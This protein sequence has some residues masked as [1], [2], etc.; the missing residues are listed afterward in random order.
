M[1]IVQIEYIN[2]IIIQS[3]LKKIHNLL[4]LLPKK[5]KWNYYSNI[6]NLTILYRNPS[7]YEID[8]YRN[9]SNTLTKLI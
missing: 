2:M 6:I 7:I 9:D 5:L 1:Y 4:N 8:L 3:Q